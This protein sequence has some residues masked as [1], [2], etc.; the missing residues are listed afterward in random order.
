MATPSDMTR[1]C[2]CGGTVYQSDLG[3]KSLSCRRLLCAGRPTRS[4]SQAYRQPTTAVEDFA[5]GEHISMQTVSIIGCGYTGLRLAKRWLSRGARVRGFATRPK[6]LRDIAGAG[7]EAIELNLDVA[8]LPLDFD[9]QL[10]YYTVPPAPIGRRDERLERLLDHLVGKPMRFVY[11]STTGVYGNRNGERVDEEA[12]PAPQSERA[13]R[14][15]AA[16]SALRGWADKCKVSWCILR[17][18]GIYGPDRLPLERLW[19]GDPTL[20]PEEATPGNRIHVD[21]LVTACIAAGVTARADRR[22]YNVTDGSS[23]SLTD[24][25]QRVARISNLPSPPLI[26]LSEAER[27]LSARAWSLLGESR[28]V[29]NKRMLGELGITLAYS[30]LDAGIRAS[31][32]RRG[33]D[34]SINSCRCAIPHGIAQKTSGPRDLG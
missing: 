8:P 24:Y 26:R 13:F 18:P 30:D 1:N 34:I 31:L 32:N 22:I 29:D 23:D 21:D 12:I 14:R 11:L 4:G 9:G 28:R 17:V 20:L 27:L 2:A 5:I 19:R 7:A 10:V 16:E 15:L 3:K 33:T 6:S 25:L